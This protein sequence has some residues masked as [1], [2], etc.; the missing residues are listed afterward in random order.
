MS[1]ASRLLA[2]LI[3]GIVWTIAGFTV[4]SRPLATKAITPA[5]LGAAAKCVPSTQAWHPADR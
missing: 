1:A 3:A 2:T 5:V 4:A